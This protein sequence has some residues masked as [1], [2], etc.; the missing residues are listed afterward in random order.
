MKKLPIWDPQPTLYD[1]YGGVG[2]FALGLIDQVSNAVLIEENMS[3]LNVARTN[4]AYNQLDNIDIIDGRVEDHLERHLGAQ[5]HGVHVAVID[6]PR[7][8][9]SD[10]ASRLIAEAK[11]L[12]HLMYLSC[13]PESLTHD[14]ECFLRNGWQVQKVIPFDFFPKTKHLETLVLL[15]S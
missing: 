4:I 8:G 2:L 7:A 6:P 13:N 14:L 12:R 11:E 10:R 1:L 9:L 15:K 5:K 3:S